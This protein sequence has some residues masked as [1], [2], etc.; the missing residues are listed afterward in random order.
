MKLWLDD[1]RTAPDGWYWVK[2][3]LEAIEFMTV[4]HVDEVELDHDLGDFDENGKERTGYDVL[5]WMVENQIKPEKIGVHTAD[6]VAKIDME[7]LVRKFL[8]E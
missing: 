2:T 6:P 8:E 5:L 7:L 4:F 3:Y 1:F